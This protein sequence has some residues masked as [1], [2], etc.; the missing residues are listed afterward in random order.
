MDGDK[1]GQKSDRTD[2]KEI[3]TDRQAR[4]CLLGGTG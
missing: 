4:M 3:Q 1:E 2:R